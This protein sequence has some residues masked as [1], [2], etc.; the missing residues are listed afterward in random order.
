MPD[1][2]LADLNEF[3]HHPAALLTDLWNWE[4]DFMS[5]TY[6]KGRQRAHL[7]PLVT[8]TRQE[9]RQIT[10]ASVATIASGS[11]VEVIAE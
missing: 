3:Q 8:T 7:L 2:D 4:P 6:H 5:T 9:E 11:K 1:E 10:L